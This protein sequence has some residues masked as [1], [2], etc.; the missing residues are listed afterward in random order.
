MPTVCTY[1]PNI[2]EGV[3]FCSSFPTILRIFGREFACILPQRCYSSTSFLLVARHR[4]AVHGY[5]V[6]LLLE[7][8]MQRFFVSMCCVPTLIA[9]LVVLSGSVAQAGITGSLVVSNNDETYTI[10]VYVNNVEK[11]TVKPRQ[12]VFFAVNDDADAETTLFARDADGRSW[13]QTVKE[14]NGTGENKGNHLWAIT[15][16]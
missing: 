1:V 15:P 9:A 14:P 16:Q 2:L 8:P 12:T 13:E 11:G 6:R 10:T 5:T 3:H 4:R 7:F